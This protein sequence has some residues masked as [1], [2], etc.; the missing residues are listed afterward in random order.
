MPTVALELSE[1][2]DSITRPVVVG[3]MN[4]LI[5]RFDLP[6]TTNINYEG[7]GAAMLKQG[8][9]LQNHDDDAAFPFSPQANIDVVEEYMDEGVLTTAVQRYNNAYVF[10]DPHLHVNIKPVYTLCETTITLEYRFQNKNAALR[11]RDQFRRKMSEGMMVLLHEVIYHYPVPKVFNVILQEIHDKREAVAGYGEDFLTWLCKYYI[12]TVTFLTNLNGTHGLPAIPEKQIQVQGWLSFD[13]QPSNVQKQNEEGAWTVGFDYKFRY[14]KPTAM[15]MEYPIVIH[16]QLLGDRFVSKAVP[17]NPYN[18][19]RRPNWTGYLNDNFSLINYSPD[20]AF[21]GYVIPDYDDWMPTGTNYKEVP[22][23]TFLVGVEDDDPKQ[24]V[25]LLELGDIALTQSVA[26]YLYRHRTKITHYQASVF[27]LTFYKGKQVMSPETIEVDE[28]L[29]V[30]SVQ[31]LNPRDVHHVRLSLITDLGNLSQ[32]AVDNLRN[33]PEV[34]IQVVD[35]L[36]GLQYNRVPI[37]ARVGG[38]AGAR[39]FAKDRFWSSNKRRRPGLT[40]PSGSRV[41][42]KPGNLYPITGDQQK[43]QWNPVRQT[44]DKNQLAPTFENYA[45]AVK[46][47]VEVV[48]LK[49]MDSSGNQA[50]LATWKNKYLSFV[51][52]HYLQA[53]LKDIKLLD[54]QTF[55]TLYDSGDYRHVNGNEAVG[56]VITT[57]GIVKPTMKSSGPRRLTSPSR[58]GIKAPML[59]DELVILGGKLITKPSFELV[60]SYLKT[61]L[62]LSSIGQGQ[63]LKTVVQSGI[64]ADKEQ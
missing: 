46:E 55:N 45:T 4:D 64:I 58:P 21:K 5:E 6:D 50:V 10:H 44:L 29:N 26:N 2:Q 61:T 12:D 7:S 42:P 31:D 59:S 53:R 34:C 30:R 35:L 16:N 40:C 57:S 8:S 19:P 9:V 20:M 23:F 48:A 27:H 49:P 13:N 24:I 38:S 52:E 22:L 14:N 18:Q 54:E 63:G 1:T 33:D 32:K 36:D 60:V 62:N 3:V 11:W 39:T 28:D 56:E 43:D 25:N 51:V 15:V 37:N 47:G 41:R 17:Y